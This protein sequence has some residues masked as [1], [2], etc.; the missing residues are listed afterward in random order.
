M[1]KGT[2]QNDPPSRFFGSVGSSVL[3][4]SS[5]AEILGHD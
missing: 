3:A 5:Q 4:L 1:T 2:Q